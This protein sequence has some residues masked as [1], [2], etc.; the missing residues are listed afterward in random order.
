MDKKWARWPMVFKINAFKFNSLQ[1]RRLVSDLGT[2]SRKGYEIPAQ[3][4]Y[5]KGFQ[6]RLEV[7][8]GEAWE[9]VCDKV[10]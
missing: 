4:W 8:K 7:Y 5:F 1:S 10:F 2:K 9:W 6:E 3:Q